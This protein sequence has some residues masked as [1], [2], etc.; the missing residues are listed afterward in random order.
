VLVRRLIE[1]QKFKAAAELLHDRE[2]VRSAQW[3]RP[4]ER[5]TGI[6]GEP[7]ERELEVDLFGLLQAF[8]AV[9]RR[10][11][12]RPGVPVPGAEISIETRTSQLMERLSE[13]EACGF[14]D[15]F[16]GAHSRSDLITT[17]LAL[18]EMI[19]LR[20]I[21]VFQAGGNGPIRVYLRERPNGAPPT[22]KA[23]VDAKKSEV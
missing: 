12:E 3:R 22:K 4:D 5:I 6:A 14:E 2:T 15:L 10:A 8:E 17:F 16:D 11:R 18:L 7:F 9:L 1:H 23:E 21:R 20:L 19:R 13:T